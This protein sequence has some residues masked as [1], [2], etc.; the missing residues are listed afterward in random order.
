MPYVKLNHHGCRAKVCAVCYGRS[1]SKAAQSVSDYLE[2]GIKSF[3]FAEYSKSDEKFPSGICITCR[4][5]LIEQM[6][7]VSLQERD[8]PRKLMLPDPDHYEVQL[9]RVTRFSQQQDCGCRICLL[10]RM[11]GLEWKK[12][13]ADCKKKQTDFSPGVQYHRLCKDCFASIYRG[14]NH[15]ENACRSRRQTLKNVA[16]VIETANTSMD[17]VTSNYLKTACAEG[18]SSSLALR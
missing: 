13:V 10:A 18:Q 6:T 5:T 2:E 12:F 14:S 17:L 9:D 15:S 4:L 8:V 3:V 16:G 1:G 7:G 11:N